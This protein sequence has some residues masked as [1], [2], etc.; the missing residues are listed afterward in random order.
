MKKMFRILSSIV[1]A[2]T[3]LAPAVFAE[4]APTLSS[5]K[6]S[7]E[8]AKVTTLEDLDRKFNLESVD[9][10]PKGVIPLKF[11]SVTEADQYLSS[12]YLNVSQTA[13]NDNFS[14]MSESNAGNTTGEILSTQTITK[15]K[16]TKLQGRINLDVTAVYILKNG[17]IYSLEK[18]TSDIS[19]ETTN[20]SWKQTSYTEKRLD[21]NRTI[22]LTVYGELTEYMYVNGQIRKIVTSKNVYV[23]FHGA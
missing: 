8:E 19:G 2:T 3:L 20:F 22:A 13:D 14:Q 4:K 6:I 15:T 16:S 11:N 21:A 23:E 1:L 18:V 5:E 17:Y 9:V 12:K 10:L 7:T